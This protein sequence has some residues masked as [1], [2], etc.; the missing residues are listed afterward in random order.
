MSLYDEYNQLTDNELLTRI[1]DM[2]ENQENETQELDFK[3]V[4]SLYFLLKQQYQPR[5]RKDKKCEF[6]KDLSAF[7]NAT[8]GCLIYGIEES[9]DAVTG[10]RSIKSF[11]RGMKKSDFSRD[12]LIQIANSSVIPTITG[13]N[14]KTVQHPLDEDAFIVV[15]L[16][17]ETSNGAVMVQAEGDHS[18]RYFQRQV[19]ENRPMLNWQVRLVNNKAIHPQLVLKFDTKA[20]LYFISYKNNESSLIMKFPKIKNIGKVLANQVGFVVRVPN[21]FKNYSNI[22]YFNELIHVRDT[23]EYMEKM[24]VFN[25][26]I[27][28]G[29][30][31]NTFSDKFDFTIDFP[32][33]DMFGVK[34]LNHKKYA[35]EFILYADNAEFKRYKLHL[36]YSKVK[37]IKDFFS[38]GDSPNKQTIMYNDIPEILRIERLS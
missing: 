38:D 2:V 5:D 3:R 22:N 21:C 7:T 19:T 13:L 35:F 4:D 36:D 26:P 30:E 18:Y 29:L 16:I 9:Y 27:F 11:G 20:G 15:I 32:A 33:N 24:K 25:H 6:A 12:Q 23:S 1:H 8:G 10:K 37:N 31:I 34:M 14:V 17:P 28:P